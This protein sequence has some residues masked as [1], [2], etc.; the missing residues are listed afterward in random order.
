CANIAG[1][2]IA[3]GRGRQQELAIRAALGARRWRLIRQ[4]LAENLLLCTLGTGL[5]LLLAYAG[6]RVLRGAFS[7][8][9]IIAGARFG[10]DRDVLIFTV[11][12]A[13]FSLL[14]FGLAPAVKLTRLQPGLRE[15][16]RTGS[17]GRSRTRMRRALVVSEIAISLVLLTGAGLMTK[18]FL[19]KMRGNHGFNPQHVLTAEVALA[20]RQFSDPARQAAFFQQLVERLRGLPGVEAAA[21]T[22]SLPMGTGSEMLPFAIAGRPPLPESEQP[23]ATHFAVTPQYFHVMQIPLLQGRSFTAADHAGAP[24]VA[25]VSREF[26]RRFFP[27]GNAL[28]EHVS[29]GVQG[30]AKRQLREIIGVVGDV[31]EWVGQAASQPQIYDCY[32]QFPARSMA[33]AVRSA[34]PVTT[35][36]SALRQTVWDI[37]KDQPVSEI[38]PMQKVMYSHGGGAG[39]QLIGELLGVFAGLA[40]MLAAIGIYGVIAY[41]VAQRTHELGIRVALGAGKREILR[42][43]MGEGARLAALGLLFGG[44]GAAAVPRVLSSALKGVPVSSWMIFL[45]SFALIAGVALGASY[46][47]A[48]RAARVDPIVALKYE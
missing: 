6:I 22:S 47:P 19:Q 28:G 9:E 48:R 12:L 30:G 39:G 42:L 27:A 7:F 37:N 8:N 10:L 20:S 1:L 13:V 2:L 45:S 40:L 24:P 3:R 16:S 21:A 38:M 5:G 4:L 41:V 31:D 32:L 34:A 44:L 46:I 43:V 29:V 15:S 35:L 17:A 25:M 33:V 26:V 18:M 36:S 23:R 14:L 11:A